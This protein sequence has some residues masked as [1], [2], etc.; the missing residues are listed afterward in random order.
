M[1][2]TDRLSINYFQGTSEPL[3]RCDDELFFHSNDASDFD[4]L[5]QGDLADF[6]IHYNDR[7]GK[8]AADSVIKVGSLTVSWETLI[9][10]E[11]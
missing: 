8:Y 2:F 6:C 4:Q 5:E 11:S 10:P 9:L 3:L 1:L 7:S